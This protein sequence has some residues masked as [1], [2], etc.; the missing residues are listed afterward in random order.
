MTTD[1]KLDALI[2]ELKAVAILAIDAINTG[3][4][5]AVDALIAKLHELTK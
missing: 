4:R 2:V 1:E 5:D 3:G